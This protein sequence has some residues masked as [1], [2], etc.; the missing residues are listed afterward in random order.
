MF[1][2]CRARA[3]ELAHLGR[4]ASSLLK[5]VISCLSVFSRGLKKS[6]QELY[7]L[8]CYGELRKKI[9]GCEYERLMLPWPHRWLQS[10]AAF[11]TRLGFLLAGPAILALWGLWSQGHLFSL[12]LSSNP[13]YL[14]LRFPVSDVGRVSVCTLPFPHPSHTLFSCSAVCKLQTS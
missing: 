2:Q 11:H 8:I 14:H 3:H 13:L 12:Q 9:G 5:P 4:A 6:S 10:D 7:G 1:C